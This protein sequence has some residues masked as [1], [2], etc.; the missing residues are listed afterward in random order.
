MC[1]FLLVASVLAAYAATA[2][3]HSPALGAE[4][5]LRV[6]EPAGAARQAWPVT[7]GIPFAEGELKDPQAVALSDDSGGRAPLQTE[8]LARWPDGSIRWLLADFQVDLAPR[9]RKGVTLQ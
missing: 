2:R 1:R 4:L 9:P 8:V 7:S 3:F 6:E 5:K